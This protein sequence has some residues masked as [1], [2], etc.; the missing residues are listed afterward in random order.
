[1]CQEQTLQVAKEGELHLPVPPSF[2]DN[3]QPIFVKLGTRLDSKVN[4]RKS[5]Q[6]SLQ[7][8]YA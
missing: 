5:R 4:I 3:R 2:L 8:T 7:N 6:S 1:M